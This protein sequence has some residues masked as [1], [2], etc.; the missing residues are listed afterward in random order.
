QQT[1][2]HLLCHRFI[3][4]R[5]MAKHYA[6]KY[7]GGLPLG[8][9][10]DDGSGIRLGESVGGVADRMDRVSAWRFINPPMAWAKGIVVNG[11]GER[12]C[13]ETVYGSLLGERMCE[14][15]EGRA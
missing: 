10:G 15:Q 6:P 2:C 8:T 4:N 1:W 5:R 12:Y 7:R 3:L 11:R 13:D 14:K 9:A